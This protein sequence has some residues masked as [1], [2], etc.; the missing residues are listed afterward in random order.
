MIDDRPTEAL[1]KMQQEHERGSNQ[2][3]RDEAG[4]GEAGYQE[5]CGRAIGALALG[6][7]SAL[8]V[9]HVAFWPLPLMALVLS[10]SA[11]KRI[12]DLRP[13]VKGRGIALSALALSLVFGVSGPLQPLLYRYSMRAQAE[14]VAAEW[15]DCLRRGD[16]SAAKQLTV[17]NWFR[18]TAGVSIDNYQARLGTRGAHQPYPEQP[19]VKL[20]LG[21]GK[22]AH[23]RLCKHLD[24]TYNSFDETDRVE[25]IYTVEDGSAATPETSF[26]KLTL[27]RRLD[28]MHRVRSWELTKAELVADPSTIEHA[29]A[30]AVDASDE[31]ASDDDL[32]W[33]EKIRRKIIRKQQQR[34]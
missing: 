24:V 10:I 13:D 21:L 1:I 22:S 29:D 28:L 12:H 23:V 14:N 2:P 15:F 4:Y 31:A 9:V 18:S 7:A 30:A 25:D 20:L 26:V 17:P 34:R 27:T 8:A 6:L 3:A 19:A 33:R 11:L 16:A 32:E 5:L